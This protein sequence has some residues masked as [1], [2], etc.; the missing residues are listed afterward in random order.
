MHHSVKQD[1]AAH[2]PQLAQAKKPEAAD[3]ASDKT[4]GA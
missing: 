4:A 1:D 2:N 3:E